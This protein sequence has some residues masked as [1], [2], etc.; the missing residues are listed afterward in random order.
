M[1]AVSFIRREPFYRA[2]AFRQG[3]KRVGFTLVD[4]LRPEGPEDWAIFWNRKAGAEEA[5]AE[6][7]E[8]LGG[9]VII[10]ENA[11]LQK[12]DKTF[13]AIS[14]H[15]HAGSGWSPVGPEDRFTKLG[16]TLKPW[17]VHLVGG[18]RLVCG[19]RSIGSQLMRS[20]PGWAEKTAQR[21]R[22]KG[23]RYKLRLHPGNWAPKIPLIDDL[24]AC[25]GV[26]IWSSAC[27]VLSLVEGIEVHH[28]APHWICENGNGEIERKFALH[29]M[30]HAQWHHEEIA[31]GTPFAR[32]I[33]QRSKASW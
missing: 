3:L 17:G 9:T 30:S 31:Q 18:H 28:S 24:R 20:P 21:L 2:E 10:A 14:V 22:A 13:Y 5:K 15:G 7:F 4:S 8:R 1:R 16:F 6:E 33:E 32:I 29:R 12:V 26:D 19:Q 27:G 23:I 11:Y 25:S